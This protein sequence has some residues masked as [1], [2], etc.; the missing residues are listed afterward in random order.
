MVMPGIHTT[1]D[2]ICSCKTHINAHDLAYHCRLLVIKVCVLNIT[3]NTC[4]NKETRS[5]EPHKSTITVI[6]MPVLLAV[7]NIQPLI[8]PHS[9]KMS[10]HI[11][12]I[13][14]YLDPLVTAAF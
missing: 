11:I 14:L 4:K 7:H 5:S 3:N 1:S 2:T 8:H 9:Q 10:P 6:E 12:V 13:S